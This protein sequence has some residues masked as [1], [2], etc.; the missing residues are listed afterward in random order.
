MEVHKHLGTLSQN[1]LMLAVA[2]SA[3]ILVAELVGGFIANS[4]ALISDSGHVFTD[5]IAL[6]LS[7]FG[8][9]QAARPASSKMTFG[10]HRIGILVALVN[11]MLIFVIALVIIFEAVQRLQNPEEVQSLVMFGIAFVGLIANVIVLL[12]LRGE[13]SHSLNIRSALL[14]AGGDALASVGVIAGGAIIYFTNWLW[15]DPIVS[16]VIALII[17]IAGLGIAWEAINVIM[18]STPKNL[19]VDEMV[20]A[21]TSVPGVQE[22]HDLPVWSLTPELLAL[23]CHLRVDDSLLSEKGLLLAQVQE[24]LQERYNICHST[25]QLECSGCEGHGLFCQLRPAPAHEHEEE[26]HETETA[27]SG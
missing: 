20:K 2:L 13:A 1:R 27:K 6:S 3:T 26:H 11:S 7:W 4:L 5:V 25:I 18:E 8:L 23:S 19:N 24:I 10:Y 9:A 22:M 14:H 17:A 15:V 12:W 21:V 16:I